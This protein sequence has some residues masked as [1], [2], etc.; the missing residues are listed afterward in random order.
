MLIL[1]AYHVMITV[2]NALKMILL[3]VLAVTTGLF[4]ITLA[5]ILVPKIVC[6]V[7]IKT[8]VLNAFQDTFLIKVYAKSV[9]IIA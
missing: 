8:F 1:N 5:A 6:N 9:Q 4:L 7:R 2:K 3:F